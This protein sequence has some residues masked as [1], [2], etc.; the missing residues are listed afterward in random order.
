MENSAPPPPP[1]LRDLLTSHAL[2]RYAL[3]MAKLSKKAV[4]S[5]AKKIS[6]Q[7]RE[8]KSVKKAYRGGGYKVPKT[9]SK[10]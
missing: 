7:Q 9:R 2:V 3:R 5:A 8:N 1:T 6:K 4:S 10:Y